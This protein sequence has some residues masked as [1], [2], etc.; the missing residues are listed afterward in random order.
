VTDRPI[1]EP[2]LDGLRDRVAQQLA[3]E[4]AGD[5]EGWLSMIDPVLWAERFAERADEPELSAGQLRKFMAVVD[6]AELQSFRVEKCTQS[7]P[8]LGSR[9]C[10]VIEFEVLYNSDALSSFRTPWVLDGGRWFT[11]AIG[12]SRL[13]SARRATE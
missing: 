5:V 1:D 7:S 8:S 3:S 11:R 12:K 2:L 4:V 13:P 10:A 6:S 9:P